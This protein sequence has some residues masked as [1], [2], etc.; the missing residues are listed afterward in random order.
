MSEMCKC[1]KETT[2]VKKDVFFSYKSLRFHFAR[3]L[4]ECNGCARKKAISDF[5][6][7]CDGIVI[8]DK[9]KVIVNWALYLEQDIS[10]QQ[11][12]TGSLLKIGILSETASGN[13]E[14]F[15]MTGKMGPSEDDNGAP[16]YFKQ[17]EDVFVLAQSAYSNVLYDWEIR[18]IAEV[19]LR[20]EVLKEEI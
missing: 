10:V 9:E 15:S 20:S 1:G 3:P 8:T 19:I 6:E 17:K 12:I 7:H 18:R 16:I 4:E 14:I 2:Y 13:W 5:D 11:K